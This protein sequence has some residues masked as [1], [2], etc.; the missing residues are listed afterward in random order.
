M[1][2][3]FEQYYLVVCRG[4]KSL[5]VHQLV[6]LLTYWLSTVFCLDSSP[7]AIERPGWWRACSWNLQFIIIVQIVYTSM[8]FGDFPFLPLSTNCMCLASTAAVHIFNLMA[9]CLLI[10]IKIF[11][12][13]S[14]LYFQ[15]TF[16]LNSNGGFTTSLNKGEFLP[17]HS[18]LIYFSSREVGTHC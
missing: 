16:C 8:F 11:S 9:A 14:G 5:L 6:V 4:L 10:H 17:K 12:M 18:N 7:A 13:K 2:S 1:R 15:L 3:A